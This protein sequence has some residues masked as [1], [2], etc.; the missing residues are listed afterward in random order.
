MLKLKRFATVALIAVA[1]S[2]NFQCDDPVF[3]IDENGNVTICYYGVTQTVKPK[4]ATRY[5]KIGATVGACG[6]APLIPIPQGQG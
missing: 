1:G 3:P 2:V 6:S 5:L 4:I